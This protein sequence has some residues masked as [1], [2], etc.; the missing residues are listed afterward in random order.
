MDT[1]WIDGILMMMIMDA[2]A[3]T[4]DIDIILVRA[5]MSSRY[6]IAKMS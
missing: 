4:C 6:D 3:M 5:K 1:P 2:T